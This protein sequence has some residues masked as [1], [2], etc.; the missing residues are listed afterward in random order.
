MDRLRLFSLVFVSTLSAVPAPAQD[1]A[2][3][4]RA[5]LE[6]QLGYRALRAG[7]IPEARRRFESALAAVPSF[8]EAHLGLGQLAMQDRRFADALAEFTA[9][10]DGY[11]TLRARLAELESARRA[12]QEDEIG[13]IEKRLREF[14]GRSERRGPRTARLEERLRA[15]RTAGPGAAVP[16]VPGDIS[17]CIGNALFNLGRLDEAVRNWE[18][19]A[20]TSPRDPM[21]HNN[22]AVGYWKQ[23]RLEAAAAALR[24]ARQLGYRVSPELQ[25]GIAAGLARGRVAL[26]F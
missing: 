2:P 3:L 23:G 7:D 12:A 15:L 16:D 25:A 8:P 18:I 4:R 19:A 26:A 9:A 17:F 14:D 21:I 22:L 6:Y 24:Q 13:A 10:R 1:A 20:G 11:V 5:A